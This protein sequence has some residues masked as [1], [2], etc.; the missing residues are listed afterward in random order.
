[1]EN[2]LKRKYIIDQNIKLKKKDQNIGQMRIISKNTYKRCNALY[3]TYHNT[4]YIST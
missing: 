2:A 4:I 3:V 1:M